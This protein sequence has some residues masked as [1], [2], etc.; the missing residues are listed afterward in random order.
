MAGSGAGATAFVEEAPSA[1][2]PAGMRLKAHAAKQ[3]SKANRFIIFPAATPQCSRPETALASRDSNYLRRW[4]QAENSGHLS[5]VQS[6]KSKVRLMLMS[7][8]PSG[9]V[10]IC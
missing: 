4:A 10:E 2:D 3:S 8:Y 6:P 1:A 7:S 9:L 5:K